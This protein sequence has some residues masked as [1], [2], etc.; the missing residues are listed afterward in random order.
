LVSFYNPLKVED[1]GI[2]AAYQLFQNF[3]NPFNPSTTIEFTL[4]ERSFVKLVVFNTLG[5]EVAV[6]VNEERGAGTHQI[7]WNAG[8]FPSGIY[9][10]R[11][12][13]RSTTFGSLTS[14]KKMLLVK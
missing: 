4:P 8:E 11:L 1:K 3:P 13:A 2:P 5:Q 7:V 9:F 6:L 10:Y 12:D 14:E